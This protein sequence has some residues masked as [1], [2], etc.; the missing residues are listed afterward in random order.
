M[1]YL[2]SHLTRHVADVEYCS[3]D[4]RLADGESIDHET[5]LDQA[6]RELAHGVRGDSDRNKELIEGR[7]T[8]PPPPF[9]LDVAGGKTQR[10]GDIGV[11]LRWFSAEQLLQHLGRAANGIFHGDLLGWSEQLVRYKSLEPIE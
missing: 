7:L 1:A 5:A 8:F 2:T 11:R 6:R 10:F 9:Q 4:C 3:V